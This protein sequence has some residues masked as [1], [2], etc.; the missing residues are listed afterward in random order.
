LAAWDHPAAV[1]A[2]AAAPAPM[3][4]LRFIRVSMVWPPL[5]V[6]CGRE[7]FEKMYLAEA[8]NSKKKEQADCPIFPCVSAAS[9]VSS[10]FKAS[11][12]VWFSVSSQYQNIPGS[13]AFFNTY[14]SLSLLFTNIY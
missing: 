11:S 13:G 3:N 12:S 4:P 9:L 7:T 5:Y 14:F 6:K 1:A 8:Q 2:A 10:S